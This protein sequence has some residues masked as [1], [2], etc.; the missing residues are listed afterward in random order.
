MGIYI[1]IVLE[2]AHRASNI[3]V[4]IQALYTNRITAETVK[5]IPTALWVVLTIL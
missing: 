3:I 4:L 5:V 1:V 2:E